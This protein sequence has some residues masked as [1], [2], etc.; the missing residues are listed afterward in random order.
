MY[1]A[2][3]NRPAD[4]IIKLDMV[5]NEFYF[6]QGDYENLHDAINNRNNPIVFLLI[7]WEDEDYKNSSVVFGCPALRIDGVIEIYPTGSDTPWCFIH[8]DGTVAPIE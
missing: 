6:V 4:F 7:D 3:F 5:N 8:S 2:G 1:L